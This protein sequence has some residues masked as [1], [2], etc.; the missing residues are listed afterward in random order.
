MLL[1]T[2]GNTSERSEGDLLEIS[3]KLR[4]RALPPMDMQF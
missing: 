1:L 4:L 2:P 3:M